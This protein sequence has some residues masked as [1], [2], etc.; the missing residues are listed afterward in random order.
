MPE[1]INIEVTQPITEVDVSISTGIP[2]Q[3]VPAGGTEGQVL[4][5]AS[6]ADYAT[7]WITPTG[8]PGGGVTDHGALTGLADDDHT[9]YHNNTRGDA[10][11]S[12][13]GHA[14]AIAD[15]TGLQAALD[16]K[17]PAGSYAASSHTHTAGQITD[18]DTEVS[19]NTDVAANTAA[20]HTH[21]NSS[22]LASIQEA[23]TTILKNAYDS[24]V[25][26][27]T[28]NGTNLINHL[29]NTSN[30]HS[31]T[32]SQ[33]GLS[34]VDNTSDAN[35]PV[36]TAQ[37]TADNLRLLATANL[38]DVANTATARTNLGVSASPVWV[39]Y[40]GTSTIV[41]WSSFTV[42]NI[43]YSVSGN[44]VTVNYYIS[45]TS[46]ST[47]TSFTVPFAIGASGVTPL[48]MTTFGINDGNN[49]I[50][51]ATLTGSTVAFIRHTSFTGTGNMLGSGTKAVGG[52]IIYEKD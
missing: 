46:D 31:V 29:S 26:W 18:F 43:R 14:H 38:S 27:I 49:S 51:R 33:V 19:N 16:G 1:P 45:G 40:S 4:A 12:Q 32:K 30:P 50:L 2:G 9:Q 52:T 20:S 44:R 8:G 34:N 42:L 36:S 48:H 22:I 7:E 47:T 5:K 24:A 11:Y 37:A 39:D 23:L 3:G 28:T 41:G 25:T 6:G 17:Q 35:K 13:L 10:R 15:T 21:A